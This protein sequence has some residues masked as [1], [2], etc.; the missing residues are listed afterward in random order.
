MVVVSF[1]EPVS[2]SE[3]ILAGLIPG[4]SILYQ[5]K[6]GMNLIICR[7]KIWISLGENEPT[8]LLEG[9]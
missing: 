8:S 7:G 1:S 9:T 6:S 2:L 5:R 4:R 3:E